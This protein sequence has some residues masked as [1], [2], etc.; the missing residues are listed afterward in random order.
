MLE[1]SNEERYAILAEDS[2]LR[3]AELIEEALYGFLE[4]GRITNEAVS[5][6]QK[7]HQQM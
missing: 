6:Q 7:E 1:N 5:S 4:V 3:R 2:R